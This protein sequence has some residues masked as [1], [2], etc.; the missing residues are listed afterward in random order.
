MGYIYKIENQI[1]NKVYIGKT[2]YSIEERWKQHLYR[3]KEGKEK[4]ALYLAMKKYGIENFKITKIEEYD[5]EFLNEK[6]IEW[7]AN[8]NSYEQG[9]NMTRGG[10]GTSTININEIYQLWDNGFA[11]SEIAKFTNHNRTTIGRLLQNYS[12]YTQEEGRKRGNK[13]STNAKRKKVYIYTFS[14]L[15]KIFENTTDASDY[16]SCSERTLRTRCRN[17][18]YINNFLFSYTILTIKERL[19]ILLNRKIKPVA[20]FSLNGQ[21]L[22]FYGSIKEAEKITGINNISKICRLEKGQ[23][24]G[25]QWRF[26]KLG[27]EKI[28]PYIKG[29]TQTVLQYDLNGNFIHEFNSLT[30]AAKA[31]GAANTTGITIACQNNNRTAKGFKWRYG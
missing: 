10:D 24:G 20:Q 22:Q 31:V 15:Y 16:F 7:I 28:S 4:Y 12:N 8:Y 9:Y 23:A 6:E 2:T 29:G 30:E 11:I 13:L 18:S 27:I 1:N 21:L 3:F 19:Q 17:Q 25:Y 26:F 14:G 5:N